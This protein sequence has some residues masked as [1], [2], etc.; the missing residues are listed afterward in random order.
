MADTDIVLG[1]GRLTLNISHMIPCKMLGS[2]S[3]VL[4]PTEV[5]LDL[6]L[7]YMSDQTQEVMCHHTHA[8]S[9][10]YSVE[11]LLQ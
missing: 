4:T 11:G 5:Q 7:V 3:K 10:F 6:R 8:H 2:F 9:E 1:Y